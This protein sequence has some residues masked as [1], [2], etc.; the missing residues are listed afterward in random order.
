MYR[1]MIV[2][3]EENILDSLSRFFSKRKEWEVVTCS[4]PLQAVDIAVQSSFDLFL[5]DYRMPGMNGV[6]FLTKTKEFSPHSMRIILSGATDFDGLVEA[7]NKAEIYRFIPKPVNPNEL[8][9]T[10]NQAL[11]LNDLLK[12][13]RILAD[14]VRAQKAELKKREIA[15][16]NLVKE[17]PLLTQV[18][19]SEDGSIILDENDL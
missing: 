9:H 1:L 4:S 10:I 15:L 8:I 2:D 11:Q 3:D 19:W 17:H 5:S 7:I 14:K 6:E 16:N 13:N 12:T 18:N